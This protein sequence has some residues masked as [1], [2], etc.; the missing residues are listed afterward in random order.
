[1]PRLTYGLVEEQIARQRLDAGLLSEGGPYADPIRRMMSLLKDAPQIRSDTSATFASACIGSAIIDCEEAKAWVSRQRNG[2]IDY[3]HQRLVYDDARADDLQQAIKGIEKLREIDGRQPYWL[4]QAF[5]AA[6]VQQAPKEVGFDAT[7][8]D[9][10]HRDGGVRV[11]IS[12]EERELLEPQFLMQ[13]SLHKLDAVLAALIERLKRYSQRKDDPWRW[14]GN[15]YVDPPVSRRAKSSIRR[16]ADDILGIATLG[17][18]ASLS[19]LFRMIS[20]GVVPRR[21]YSGTKMP[22]CGRPYWGLVAEFVNASWPEPE[23]VTAE[24]L[25]QRWHQFARRRSV[26]LHNWPGSAIRQAQFQNENPATD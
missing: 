25:R 26:D 4:R 5:A 10:N 14:I 6:L 24:D 16:D 20:A 2:Q 7:F 3:W 13:V 17:L 12:A 22:S 23:P 19:A 11:K 15:L 8:P 1:M 21:R 9:P 18:A